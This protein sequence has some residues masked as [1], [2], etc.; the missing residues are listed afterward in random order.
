M[1]TQ[2]MSG[3]STNSVEAV[4]MAIDSMKMQGQ[5][6]LKLIDEQKQTTKNV[7]NPEGMGNMVD[8]YA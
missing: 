4:K 7:S 6:V 5:T 2:V 1:M 8:V 3:I